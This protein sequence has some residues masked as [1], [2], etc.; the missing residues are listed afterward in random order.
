MSARLG[1]IATILGLLEE[2]GPMTQAEMREQTSLSTQSISSAISRITK[3]GADGLRRA[4]VVS[5]RTD[6]PGERDYPRAV[7]K[8]GH[9]DNKPKP[10]AN[11]ILVKRRYRARKKARYA[12][13][14]PFR[15]AELMA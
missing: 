3:A 1:H 14:S 15:M 8:L 5:W 4:H 9:G 7:Y 12:N 6:A 13:S 11:Q 2:F 10:K